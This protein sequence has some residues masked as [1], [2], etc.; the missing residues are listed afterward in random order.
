MNKSLQ[1]G[2]L[3]DTSG[4]GN[5]KSLTHLC[6]ATRTGCACLKLFNGA[7]NLETVEVAAGR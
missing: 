3:F 2:E 6:Q 7:A 1:T 4:L 5:F